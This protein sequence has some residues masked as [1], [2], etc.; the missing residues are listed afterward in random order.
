MPESDCNMPCAGDSSQMCGAGYRLSMYHFNGTDDA[1]TTATGT[2]TATATG[3]STAITTGVNATQTETASMT[4]SA[5]GTA[6][7]TGTTT[8]TSANGTAFETGTATMTSANGTAIQTGTATGTNT[9]TFNNGTAIET[10]TATATGTL[11]PNATQTATPGEKEWFSIGC[12]I[13]VYTDVKDRIL[14]G[15][16]FW[17]QTDLTIDKC[18]DMCENG[19]YTYAGVEWGQECYCGNK[20]DSTVKFVDDSEC[21]MPCMGDA[22][23]MCGDD[24]RMG[25]FQLTTAEECEGEGATST[26]SIALL[27]TGNMLVTGTAAA[28]MKAIS[29]M[30][31]R[32][33]SATSTFAVP[34]SIQA[35]VPAT[36]TASASSVRPSSMATSVRPAS[37]TAKASSSVNLDGPTPTGLVERV[38]SN[39]P[40][41]NKA[42]EIYAHHMVG[43]TYP[44]GKADW[45]KDI[46]AA[47]AAG[48]DGFALNMGSDWWQTARVADAYA[49]AVEAGDFTMFLSLDMTAMSC[50][51][52]VDAATLVAL[53]S[54]FSKS[55]AQTLHN[56]KV[57]VST[58]SGENCAFGRS[59][60][61]DGWNTM[62]KKPLK[63]VGTDI[64]FVP[65]I[66]SD[67]STF[68]SAEW[69]D[70]ELN[71][72]SGWPMSNTPLDTSSD[73]QYMTALGDKEYMPAISPYFF[74]HFPTWG[75][76][77]NWIYRSDDFLY[78][79]RWEQ[80]IA[81]R[82]RVKFTEILTWNDYGESSYIAPT[83]GAL[84]AG[85]N[86]WVDGFP[87]DALMDVTKYYAT[88][89]K[90][91]AYPAITQD[92]V[93]WWAR[94]HPKAAH[95]NDD[96]MSRPDRWNDTDDVVY[97]LVFATADGVA[98]LT[99]GTNSER[100]A[101]KAGLNKIKLAMSPGSVT[102]K[103]SRNGANV[104]SYDS[105]GSFSYTNEPSTYNFNY[106]VGSS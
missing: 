96:Y 49:A 11:A 47:K 5:N 78:A 55:P 15:E 67:P 4:L 2:A 18:I 57:L 19:G 30:S 87:H 56:G 64:F 29:T 41:S 23:E 63:L 12:A 80:V 106:F 13:D 72:N 101:V 21:A 42:H 90:T 91:G 46:A 85:S 105:T 102:I 97:A 104:V 88:A 36:V 58:F 48:I 94:P 20:L 32:P 45:A 76:N 82:D 70:G 9:M 99:S 24:F 83:A 31:S 7:Q 77:K 59:S 50:G 61:A 38:S 37:T 66:F 52:V 62:F 40:G 60:A 68:A 27:P 54:S 98:T 3:V 35:S 81:M 75:W 43:N 69:M 65:S 17:Y 26:S 100:Y 89:F 39:I 103:V 74:T 86:M 6:V 92:K 95:A 51:N 28:S 73:E 33:A 71:W 14:K 44:Y 93:I 8:L 84:P 16:Y 79:N 1:S 22:S 34:T 10:G 53:V 25:I